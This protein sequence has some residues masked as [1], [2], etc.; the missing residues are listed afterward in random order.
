MLDEWNNTK[1]TI[2]RRMSMGNSGKNV[3]FCSFGL[4]S[5]SISGTNR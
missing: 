3:K 4:G 2:R 5:G 1:L